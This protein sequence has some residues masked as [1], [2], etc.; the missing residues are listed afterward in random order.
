[1]GL[2]LEEALSPEASTDCLGKATCGFNALPGQPLCPS[3]QDLD[4]TS[5]EIQLPLI[6]LFI[7]VNNF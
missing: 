6:I 1:M 5:Q 7:L 3:L 2:P 4:F